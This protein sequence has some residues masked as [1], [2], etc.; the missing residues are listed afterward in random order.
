[1]L[2]VMRKTEEEREKSGNRWIDALKLS[3]RLIVWMIAFL[4]MSLSGRLHAVG[5]HASRKNEC[6]E[7]YYKKQREERN[8]NDV[9]R[10]QK[11]AE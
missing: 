8:K 9:E 3:I 10:E 7:E 1:M 11:I 4:A 2:I 5:A 6:E